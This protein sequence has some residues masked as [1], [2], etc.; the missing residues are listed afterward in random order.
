MGGPQTSEEDAEKKRRLEMFRKVRA[1]MKQEDKE[2]KEA[3][4]Q[5]RVDQIE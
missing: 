5:K 4:Y 2:E 3:A 1:D